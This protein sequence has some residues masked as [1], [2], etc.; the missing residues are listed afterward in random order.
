MWDCRNGKG[1]GIVGWWGWARGGGG[2]GWWVRVG[3]GVGGYIITVRVLYSNLLILPGSNQ[4]FFQ[5]STG[6]IFSVKNKKTK[7]I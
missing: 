2:G 3:G 4:A 6:K 5:A 7:Y 1:S